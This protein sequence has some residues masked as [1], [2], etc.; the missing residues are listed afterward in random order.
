MWLRI[1]KCG[2]LQVDESPKGFKWLLC[3]KDDT[4]DSITG[5]K[6]HT[7]YY[8][9]DNNVQKEVDRES[10]IFGFRY[11]DKIIPVSGMNF[12][13]LIWMEW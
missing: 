8:Y 6:K 3:K 12:S 11:G 4:P 9:V 1:F 13:I 2:I 10:I 5:I 7:S